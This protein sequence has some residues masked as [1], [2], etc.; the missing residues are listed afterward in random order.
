M[1][2]FEFIFYL[3]VI[4]IVFTTAWKFIASIFTNLLQ[5]IGIDKDFTFLIFKTAS[6]YIL[7]TI[8]ALKTVE[9]MQGGYTFTSILFAII[10]T[11]VIYATIAGNLERNRWR[12]VLNYERKRIQVMRYDGY[13]LMA[14]IVLFIATLIQPEISNFSVQQWILQ[15]IG[16]IY[17]TPVLKFIIGFFAFFYMINMII[18]GVK[19]TDQV[20]DVLLNR[21]KSSAFNDG[22]TRAGE[23][24]YT[25]YEVVDEPKEPPTTIQ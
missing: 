24:T 2:L 5:A 25:D 13:L 8:T 7:V 15:T 20:L 9:Q 16:K 1:A 21:K 23:T 17:N 12:A 10:G 11:F 3:G 19:A 6:Y 18:S 14:C 22:N 4:V